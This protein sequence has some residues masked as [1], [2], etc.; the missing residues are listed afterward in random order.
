MN[1]C[2][3]S[4]F[5]LQRIMLLWTFCIQLLCGNMFHSIRRS[6]MFHSHHSSR[7]WGTATFFISS[8]TILKSYQQCMKVPNFL[9]S[10]SI[11][12]IDHLLNYSH[13]G[14]VWGNTSLWFL[15]LWLLMM[16]NREIFIWVLEMY[17]FFIYSRYEPLVW[18]II[19]D[20]SHSVSSFSMVSFEVQNF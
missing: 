1:I 10:S 15:F 11:F 5:W 19:A 20:L 6:G 3:V 8:C 2:V 7:F 9:I 14:V 13:P 12:F 16:L 18:Y 17:E 4:A